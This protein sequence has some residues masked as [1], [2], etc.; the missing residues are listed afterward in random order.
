MSKILFF[1]FLINIQRF[2]FLCEK[3]LV[4]SKK[5]EY[6]VTNNKVCREIF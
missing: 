3:P 1:C 5:Y 2:Q 6:L 4:L